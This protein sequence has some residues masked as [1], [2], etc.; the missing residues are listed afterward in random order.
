MNRTHLCLGSL[1]LGKLQPPL[2]VCFILLQFFVRLHACVAVY[3]NIML[4][5]TPYKHIHEY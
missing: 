2:A 4:N 3:A 1:G 5:Q